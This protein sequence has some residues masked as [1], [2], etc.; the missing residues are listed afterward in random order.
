[1]TQPT[2]YNRLTSFANLQALS[3]TGQ[4]PGN[5]LDS[6]F[7]AIK[8]TTDGVL[9]NLKLLQN[10]DGT[11]LNGS[12]GTAQLSS[13]LTAG[14]TAPSAWVTGK[15]YT[16]SPASTVLNGSSMYICLVSHTSG[17]F[18]TDLAAAKWL[19]ILNL[20]AITLVNAN[21]IAVTPN[22]GLV[23]SDVQTSLNAIDAGK[24]ASSHTH[25]STQISDST[26]DGRAF[27]T[28]TLAGQ[29]ALL[30]LGSLAFLS[31]VPVT[32]IANQLAFTGKLTPTVLAASTND[33]APTGIA[34]NAVIELSAS[35]PVNL[36][37]LLATT[38]GDIKFLDNIGTNNITLTAQDTASAAANRF[39]LPRP[40]VLRPGQS[41]VVKYDG[42][43]TIWRLQSPVPTNPSA[44]S[45][46][47]LVLG[48][49]AVTRFVNYTAPGAPDTG[50]VV[51]YDELVLED[52]N[53]ETWRV[54]NGNHTISTA[55]TGAVNGLESA[56]SLVSQKIFV[57]V[58]GN[59]KTAVI[60]ALMSLS[61][62]APTLPS[63]FTFS[64]R[65]GATFT[66]AS[67]K[68]LRTIQTGRRTAYIPDATHA[69]PTLVSG[70]GGTT[71]NT[72][73]F[74]GASTGIGAFIPTTAYAAGFFLSNGASATKVGLAPSN[75]YA[76]YESTTPIP[77][78]FNNSDAL[79]K[80][81]FQ[82]ETANVFYF[83]GAAS[84][85]VQVTHWDDNI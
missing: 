61:S 84:S 21:Q 50:F 13:A 60:G 34:T 63:G 75:N 56:F 17:T 2:T 73:A 82:L 40:L 7:N 9:T 15:A 33:Y 31:S 23:S 69:F 47:N 8:T 70:T 44:A 1:M 48:N 76:G 14:F 57:W 72:A 68:L 26:T 6:E 42:A 65:I 5:S 39:S 81:E 52:A 32:A 19:L 79:V 43:N 54:A 85:L 18:A 64:I 12:I 20:A 37:G 46:K 11:V 78:F 55:T 24:A 45:F 3:P 22:G 16:A 62:T 58:I 30:G 66:D 77:I 38:D 10:D 36:T 29:K 71:L 28:T 41:A 51:T 67:S 4:P 49:A 35:T 59:P 83:G 80:G 27:L 25:P 53:G 74:N